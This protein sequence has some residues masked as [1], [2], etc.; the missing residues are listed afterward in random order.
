M[1]GS[2]KG[3]RPEG[4]STFAFAAAQ[5]VL[6][7]GVNS[8][9]RA[10]K[11]VGGVPR[12]MSR[13][14]GAVLVDVDGNEYVDYVGGWGPMILGHVDE[15]AKAAAGKALCKGWCFGTPTAQET[16]IAERVIADI[17]SIEVIRFVNSGT[18]ATMSA[19]RLARGFTGRDLIVK[20]DGC[21]HGHADG[22]LV[23]AGSGATTFGAPSSAGVPA[24]MA[25]G[26][27]RVPYNDLGSAGALFAAH[28]RSIAAFIL[29]P[30]AGNMGCVPPAEGYLA[31]L[32]SLCDEYGVLLVFDEVITGYRVGLGGAQGRYGVRPDIT[33][34]GKIIGGGLP[35][36]AYGARREIMEWLSPLGPVYQAG[37]LAGNPLAMAVGLATL[38]ALHEPGVYARLESLSARL[39]DGLGAAAR[40]A[41]VPICQNR[42]GSMSTV[43]FQA[44]PVT[45]YASAKKSDVRAYGLFFQEML[46]RGFYL[47]PAQFEAAF[48]SLTHTERQIDE[49][50]AAAER[51]FARVAGWAA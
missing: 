13:A 43:F 5:K 9:V 15:R 8:P 38:E 25:A 44:G 49:T 27:L 31:G 46:N 21:Y 10:F 51:A 40:A 45:N 47:P 14:Q 3:L 12:F 26:T 48:V 37:T 17:P 39:A 41:G 23:E 50:L 42:V 4:G 2:L 29:E 11:A 30:I 19:I 34:L 22:L 36:G 1:A 35:V 7:G 6:A 20:C 24:A 16:A 28:G 18:E 32:R 33:C